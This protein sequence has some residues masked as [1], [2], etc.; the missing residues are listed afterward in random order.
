MRTR[1]AARTTRTFSFPRPNSGQR[2][3]TPLRA[4]S[5]Q[6]V[7]FATLLIPVIPLLQKR[8]QI[9]QSERE[10][11]TRA[12]F[13]PASNSQAHKQLSTRP[14][15]EN[16]RIDRDSDMESGYPS[17]KPRSELETG[18]SFPEPEMSER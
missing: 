2:P 15:T 1:L 13:G 14:G 8:S 11:T 4:R 3:A 18:S 12:R 5:L 7:H 17:P 9:L 16:G 10:L 6:P